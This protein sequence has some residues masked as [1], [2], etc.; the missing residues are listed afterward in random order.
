MLSV[1]PAFG[2]FRW[3]TM[4]CSSQPASL[5]LKHPLLSSCFPKSTRA[6]KSWFRPTCSHSSLTLRLT[7][8]LWFLV[9]KLCFYL[10]WLFFC[11]SRDGGFL[12]RLENLNALSFGLEEILLDQYVQLVEGTLEG[13]GC[14]SLCE[15][16]GE[17]EG[18]TNE[19]SNLQHQGD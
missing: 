14:F 13:G 10:T 19:K 15:G 17:P 9:W 18:V 11:S 6:W 16:N 3:A 2:C 5:G 4:E 12:F 8:L 1:G 7:P